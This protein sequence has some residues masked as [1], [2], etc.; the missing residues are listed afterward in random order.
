MVYLN[1]KEYKIGKLDY[2]NGKYVYNSLSGEKDALNKYVGLVDYN[3]K[4]SIN[5]TSKNLF[6]FFVSNFIEE[7]K[8]REDILRKFDLK[9]KNCYEILEKLCTLNLDKF[10][11]WLSIN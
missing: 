10:K 8:E 1:Y 7:I 5:K 6:P 11:F 9:D 2:I 3:L 4:N